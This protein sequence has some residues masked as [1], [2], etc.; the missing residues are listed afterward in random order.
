M[1][2]LSLILIPILVADVINPVIFAATF[3]VLGTSHPIRNSL[4]MLL[5]FFITYYLAG[6]I[7]AIGLES[8]SD[9][10]E[11]PNGFDYIVEIVV[12]IILIIFGALSYKKDY[13]PPANKIKKIEVMTA[14]QSLWLGLKVNI[15]GLPFAIPYFG[16]IDQ[17]LKAEVPL[18]PTLFILLIYNALYIL[19]FFC[20]VL[21][22]IVSRKQSAIVFRKMN[23]WINRVADKYLPIIFVILGIALLIDGILYFL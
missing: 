1:V 12:G 4:L 20:M 17:I 21:L 16:A 9:A 23:Q 19:P 10:F 6:I 13:T 11:L 5:S 2:E 22:F 15:I 3:Y 7:I 14:T 8:F 18:I